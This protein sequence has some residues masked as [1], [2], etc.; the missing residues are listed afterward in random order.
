MTIRK[1]FIRLALVVSLLGGTGY[2]LYAFY[3]NGFTDIEHV[4]ETL[5]SGL[6]LCVAVF[7]ASWIAYMGLWII[8]WILYFLITVINARLKDV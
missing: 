7:I 5:F 2:V 3:T 4:L 8:V 1:W 6:G